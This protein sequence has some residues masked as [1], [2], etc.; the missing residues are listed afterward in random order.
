MVSSQLRLQLWAIV[1]ASPS[2]ALNLDVEGGAAQQVMGA[3]T[4][5]PC[6]MALSKACNSSHSD[7]FDCTRCAE[8]HVHDLQHVEG[9]TN[10]Q[11]SRWCAGL[12]AGLEL[13]VRHWLLARLF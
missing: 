7:V 2:A 11:I 10:D 8:I 9:C 4:T 12:P 3:D 13:P 5:D 6:R 1:F